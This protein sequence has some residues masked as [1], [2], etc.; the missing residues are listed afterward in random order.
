MEPAEVVGLVIGVVLGV[1]V[2]G[3]ICSCCISVR[4]SRADDDRRA[5]VQSPDHR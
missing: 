5:I 1:V 2:C 3:C 4:R